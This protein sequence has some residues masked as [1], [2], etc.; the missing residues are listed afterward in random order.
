MGKFSVSLQANAPIQPAITAGGEA[1]VGF[2]SDLSQGFWRS[3][4][5]ATFV[6]LYE[7]KDPPSSFWQSTGN[8]LSGRAEEGTIDE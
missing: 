6:P 2:M 3:G 7:L 1:A 4:S 5:N 8:L